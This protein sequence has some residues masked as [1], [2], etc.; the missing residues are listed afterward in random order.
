[1]FFKFFKRKDS[2]TEDLIDFDASSIS[3][4]KVVGYIKYLY[5]E[6]KFSHIGYRV[7]NINGNVRF[8]LYT[9]SGSLNRRLIQYF[10]DRCPAMVERECKSCAPC[11]GKL[12]KWDNGFEEYIFD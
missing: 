11:P 10:K 7:D 5:R 12:N 8:V 4:G 1:M 6:K 3:T 9:L 2:I